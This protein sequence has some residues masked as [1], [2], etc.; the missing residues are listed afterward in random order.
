MSRISSLI[1]GQGS[2]I[3]SK[4]EM[5]ARSQRGPR[6]W[7]QC[8]SASGMPEL[9]TKIFVIH[10]GLPMDPIVTLQDI[11]AV[12]RYSK[13]QESGDLPMAGTNGDESLQVETMTL[14]QIMLVSS[15]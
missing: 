13:R 9:A 2:R 8:H 11:N 14:Q 12:D 7:K 5:S 1:A 15:L 10:G 3:T 4:K 6:K